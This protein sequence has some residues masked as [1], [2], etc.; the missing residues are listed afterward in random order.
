MSDGSNETFHSVS[1]FL[2]EKAIISNIG[3][4]K[5]TKKLRSGD[6]LVEVQSRKQSQQIVKLKK[7]STIPIT[8]SSHASLNSS[9]AVIT[10]GELLNVPT[11]EILKELQSQGV[12]HV[13]RISIRRDG[14]LLNTKH[15]ILTFESAKLPENIKAG[16]IRLSV[17]TYIPN[18]LRCFQC[19][20]FGH[21][22]TSCRGTLTC[23]RCAEVGH[24]S[25]DC[26]RAEK[27]VNCKGEHT[28]L[29]RNC[30]AWKQE[31]E[32]ISTKIKK[33]I[34]YQEARKLVKSQTPTPGNSYVSVAK[35][36][37]SAPSVQ[38]NPDISISDSKQPD[39][40]ARASPIITNPV[41]GTTSLDVMGFTTPSLYL[42]PNQQI[43]QTDLNDLI[44]QLPDPFI[45][46]GDF[47][48]HSSIWGSSDSNSRGV[49]IEQLLTHHNLCLLNSDQQTYFHQTTKTF[50][51]IDLAICSPSIYPFFDLAIDNSLHN[52]DHFPL[53][54]NDNRN[55]HFDSNRPERYVFAAANWTKFARLSAITTNMIENSSINEAVYAIT[56]VMNDAANAAIPKTHN[57]GRKQ[58]KPWWNQ[59]CQMALNR[60]DKAWSIF[61]RYPT[62][63]NLT[64]FKMARAEFRR[65]R[66]RSE[67]AS[68]INYI[69]TITY[70]T[71][72]YKLWQKVKKASGASISNTISVL[73]VNG[74]TISSP[75]NIANSIASTLS[76][77]SSSRNYTS[78]FL[79][80][81][82][83]V[84]KQTL[85][86]SSQSYLQYNSN[87]SFQEFQSCLSTVHKS[88]PG[89]DNISYLMIQNLTSVS[90]KNL[91]RLYN[92]IWN[93][94][95]FLTLWHQAVIIPLLKT[96]KDPTNYR[97]ITLT[98]C[99]CKLLEKMIN[100]RLIYFLETNNFLHRCQSGFRK[101]LST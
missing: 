34:S 26:N 74:Q 24:E 5:C 22:K 78:I 82:S 33:R 36:S 45:L 27:C 98:S 84:E 86:F 99:L 41:R 72:S 91:L 65:I 40:I 8:V 68:W 25:T 100:R 53:T 56:K 92:R 44:Y 96:G 90:Q 79:N 80:H 88:S 9:K 23:A 87:F 52:S 21:P 51:S 14:Q 75:R 101:D 20:R 12:S 94:H 16:Y 64:A 76:D 18:P 6:L 13:R 15:L 62:T 93:E 10:C 60:Q 81:K 1:P 55:N 67:R 77:T 97:P 28:S 58:N 95:Y 19:Q 39:S 69:S 63:S 4:V 31:K 71:S 54:L 17:R 46:L 3:E 70:S 2:V 85:S 50:H 61:R 43:N 48:G 42:P 66:R 59:D 73:H 30:P 89:P 57:S 7:F 35:N 11:E 29:S 49:Q 47:N 83:E 38:I 37:F 32:I